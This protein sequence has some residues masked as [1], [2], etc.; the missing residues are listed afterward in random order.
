M[1][2]MNGYIK[3]FKVEDKN[4]FSSFSIDEGNLLEKYKAIWTKNEKVKQ[5]E[6]NA[7]P[8]YNDKHTKTKISTYG[9]KNYTNFRGLYV[10]EDD[11]KSEF[12]TI[13]STDSLLVHKK[14]ITC[15][16]I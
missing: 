13:I 12:S 1:P 4:I 6:S 14:N 10:S 3:I 16:H 11:I 7:L 5:T 15:K 2:K 8:V 9:D